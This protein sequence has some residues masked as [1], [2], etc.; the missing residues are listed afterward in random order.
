MIRLYFYAQSP[1]DL[2]ILQN[3]VQDAFI[4]VNCSIES[5]DYSMDLLDHINTL[6]P[7]HCAVF[8]DAD[9]DPHVLE[10]AR[11]IHEINPK[12][13]FNFLSSEP[14][15]IEE[16]YH[17]GVTYFVKKP[18]HYPTISRCIENVLDF[19]SD[20]Q[21]RFIGLKNRNGMDVIRYSEIKYIMSD[22]RKVIFFCN[23]NELEYYHKLDEIE[24]MLDDTFVRCHQSYIVNMNRIKIFVDDGLLLY[25]D[26]FIPISR[27]QQS[28]V[29]KKY[30]SFLTR[31]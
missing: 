16:M 17:M 2:A 27:K 8:Y 15:D 11:K 7:D 29:R 14:W 3:Y 26:T 12:H 19:F 18:Y 13:R 30:V 4:D 5:F 6:R 20:I 31:Q 9:N 24:A 22:K 1:N 25:D 28:A 23:I 21:K 10:I